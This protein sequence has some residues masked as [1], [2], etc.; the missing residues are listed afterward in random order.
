MAAASRCPG[1]AKKVTAVS[2]CISWNDSCYLGSMLACFFPMLRSPNLPAKIFST[3]YDEVIVV[4]ALKSRPGALIC[5]TPKGTCL[6]RHSIS[7]TW[8]SFALAIRWRSLHMTHIWRRA[9]CFFLHQAGEA[10]RF[11]SESSELKAGTTTYYSYLQLSTDCR[12]CTLQTVVIFSG[13]Q[14]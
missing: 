4:H 3:R 9:F 6:V 13:K 2:A 5:A 14:P 12:L 11:E 10:S 7:V 1:A 8:P